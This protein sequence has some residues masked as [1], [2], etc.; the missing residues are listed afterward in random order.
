MTDNLLLN[1]GQ[2]AS[3]ETVAFFQNILNWT[4]PGAALYYRDTELSESVIAQYSV[5][6]IIRSQVFVD[7]SSAAGKPTKNCRYAIASSKAAELYN[8]M[9]ANQDILP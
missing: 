8:A 9:P 3:E 4:F 7:V 6:Q 2:E 1:D 5:G